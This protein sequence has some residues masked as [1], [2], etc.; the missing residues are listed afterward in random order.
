MWNINRTK[1][2]NYKFYSIFTH[3]R[4]QFFLY[5][6]R[7]FYL[8]WTYSW[9][10][11]I[12]FFYRLSNCWFYILWKFISKILCNWFGWKFWILFPTILTKIFFESSIWILYE[13]RACKEV[14][15]PGLGSLTW[16]GEF[17]PHKISWEWVFRTKYTLQL[18]ADIQSVKAVAIREI[19]G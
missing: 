18:N 2:K 10:L 9:N 11:F 5:T 16:T 13:P 6:F 15:I 7:K 14:A 17:V 1:Y 3:N 12:W 4:S 19:K 8:V